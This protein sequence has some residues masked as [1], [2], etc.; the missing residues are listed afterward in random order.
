MM[1]RDFILNP[2]PHATR[3]FTDVSDWRYM[4]RL[5]F[6]VRQDQSFSK[7]AQHIWRSLGIRSKTLAQQSR[8]ER[9]HLWLDVWVPAYAG[10]TGTKRRRYHDRRQRKSPP[11]GVPAGGLFCSWK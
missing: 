5:E 11:A 3:A 2:C 9:I 4:G 6:I 10:T 7:R 8:H 1:L